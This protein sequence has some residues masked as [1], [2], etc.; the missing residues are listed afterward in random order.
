MC[1]YLTNTDAPT[2]YNNNYVPNGA[3]LIPTAIQPA[4]CLRVNLTVDF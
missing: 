1:I 4:R 3:W 2:N